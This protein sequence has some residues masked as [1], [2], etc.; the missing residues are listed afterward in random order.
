MAGG[1]V[2]L[3]IHKHENPG[4]G[5]YAP[6]EEGFKT[7]SKNQDDGTNWGRAEGRDCYDGPKKNPG[8]GRYNHDTKLKP[9]FD[10]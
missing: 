10:Y 1:P 7:K 4:P 8:P 5:T 2:H 3:N 9:F 6:V